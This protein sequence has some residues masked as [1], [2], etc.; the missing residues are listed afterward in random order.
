MKIACTDI[1]N[2][3]TDSKGWTDA[4]VSHGICYMEPAMSKL[5]ENDADLDKVITYALSKGLKLNLHAPYGINN[6]AAADSA[7]Q[8]FSVAN[9]KRT[10]DAAA[11]HKLGTVTF[12]PGRLSDDNDSPEETWA[13]MM[14]AI[15]DIAGYAKAKQVYVA[16]ENMER[17]PYELVYTMEDLN[18]FA[19][20]AENNPYFGVTVDFAHY[21]SHGVGLPDLHALKLPLYNVHLSQT[22]GGKMHCALSNA[23]HTPD[24]GEVC[25][26]LVEFGYDRVVVLE[27]KQLLESA[28]TLKAV[29][30]ELEAAADPA[31]RACYLAE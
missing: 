29:L 11:R 15:A 12:H 18:R 8:A 23:E 5:P 31:Y 22:Y 7:L 10:I 28:D 17:R 3:C 13:R 9:V 19:P 16:I 27:C 24:I 6:I 4:L 25:R 26:L 20:F 14:E 21:A 30:K 1:G 2:Y